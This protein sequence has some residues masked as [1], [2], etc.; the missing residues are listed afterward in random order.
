MKKINR[1]GKMGTV[2]LFL[3]ILVFLNLVAGKLSFVKI[4][5]T[6]E[7]IH[8]LSPGTEKILKELDDVVS[9]KFFLSENLPPKLLPLKDKLGL[10]L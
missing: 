8:E 10:L 6:Q 4:D 1:A 7:K 2:F 5:L 9:V 3:G